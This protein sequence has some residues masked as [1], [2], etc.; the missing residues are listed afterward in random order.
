MLTRGAFREER[1]GV[2]GREG[3]RQGR[4]ERE[5]GEEGKGESAGYIYIYIER[6]RARERERAG[7]REGETWTR[8]ASSIPVAP[9]VAP[10]GDPSVAPIVA[11][12]EAWAI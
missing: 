11:C 10:P 7:G 6:E 3:R 4:R 5:G 1:Q 9:A 12:V 2:R 8:R